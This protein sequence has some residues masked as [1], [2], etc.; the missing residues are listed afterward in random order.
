MSSEFVLKKSIKT[1]H[2]IKK[3]RVAGQGMERMR[4]ERRGE[5]RDRGREKIEG[6]R[7]REKIEGKRGRQ[8]LTETQRDSHR[9]TD[10]EVGAVW[11]SRRRQYSC[12]EAKLN[13][14]RNKLYN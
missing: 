12:S 1:Y 14:Q 3:E 11:E 5:G 2:W 6:K 8:R 4:K 13:N 9:H 7:E 10:R